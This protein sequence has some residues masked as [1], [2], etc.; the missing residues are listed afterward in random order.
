MNITPQNPAIPIATVVNQ[1]TDALRR[2]NIQREVI[3]QPAPTGQSPKEKGVASDRGAR[4]PA[5]QNE[6]IDFAKLQE[7]AEKAAE[8]ISG[9][10]KEGEQK[11]QNQNSE[12][13]AQQTQGRRDSQDNS[14]SDASKEET[15]VSGEPLDFA[16]QQEVAELKQRDREVRAHE[17]AH[18]AA[19]GP[20][21]GA[22]S[23]T[24]KVGPDGKRYAVEG[25]VSVDLSPVAG[26]PAA[27]IAKMQKVYSAALAP[28]NPSVQDTRVARSAAQ[29][30]AQAQSELLAEKLEDPSKERE[31]NR[32]I[33]RSDA[34]AEQER[35]QSIN[36][37]ESF[38]RLVNDTLQAQ[39]D[40][41][42]RRTDIE[43]RA[44][45]IEQFYSNI[46]LAYEKPASS[47]FE[48]IA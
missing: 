36:E 2:E 18:S 22:P 20:T 37:S 3:T 7:Q 9:D 19:G 8:T 4:T 42:K 29:L 27:T 44:Q 39:D 48:L 45:R 21:T 41:G 14:S 40:I 31:L 38:D 17:Q 24:M 33:S 47:R 1:Q 25:E 35:S 46:N 34:F 23:Y 10:P 15:T 13:S 26:N 5:Q 30:I 32:V 43:Q 28:A 11:E 16:E 6:A 12:Q